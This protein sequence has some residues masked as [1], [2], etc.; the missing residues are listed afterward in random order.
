[1]IS[2]HIC[3]ARGFLCYFLLT[4]CASPPPQALK[5]ASTTVPEQPDVPAP[6][7]KRVQ[8]Q[9]LPFKLAPLLLDGSLAADAGFDPLGFADCRENLLVYREAELKHARLA[10]LAAA[11][12]PLSE[13]FQPGLA[14]AFGLTSELNSDG[15]APSV[16]N[17]FPAPVDGVFVLLAFAAVAAVEFATFEKQYI[18]PQNFDARPAAFANK[19][20]SGLVSGD[21]GFDPLGVGSFFGAGEAGRKAMRTAELKNGRVAMLAITGFAIQEFVLKQPV[22]AQTPL[23][24]TPV[25]KLVA[26]LMTGGGGADLMPPGY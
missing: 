18:A 17:G 16:L 20:A 23:F 9:A 15:R 25:T 2:L 4:S 26:D 3:D 21:F 12:W 5:L 1:M 6:E 24:F 8:S 7:V 22:V 10:M 13:L 11:G 19:E 14:K